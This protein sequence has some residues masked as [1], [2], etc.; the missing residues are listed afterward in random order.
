MAGEVERIEIYDRGGMIRVY[1]R[2]FLV[3]LMG[4]ELPPIIYM[5]IGLESHRPVCK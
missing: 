4:R 1:T 5:K 2:S 3:S